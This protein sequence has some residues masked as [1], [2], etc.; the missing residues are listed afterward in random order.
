MI[1]SSGLPHLLLF[2]RDGAPGPRSQL[3]GIEHGYVDVDPE[4][5]GSSASGEPPKA[6]GDHPNLTCVL[7]V[8]YRSVY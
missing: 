5:L 8:A 3:L 7:V 2:F 6:S 1:S 4:I